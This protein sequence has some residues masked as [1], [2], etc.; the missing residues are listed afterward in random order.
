V[1]HALC[2]FF[3][4]DLFI[5]LGTSGIAHSVDGISWTAVASNPFSGNGQAVEW[6]PQGGFFLAGTNGGSTGVVRSSDGMTWVATDVT[7]AGTIVYTIGYSTR[8]NKYFASGRSSADGPKIDMSVDGN[9]FAAFRITSPNL[10]TIVGFA[11]LPASSALAI[12]CV[13]PILAD[14]GYPIRQ[15]GIACTAGGGTRPYSFR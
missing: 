14:E 11:E 8:E 4:F 3:V 6:I 15:F 12:S 1:I 5:Y 9:A 2:F 10:N 7:G 13:S